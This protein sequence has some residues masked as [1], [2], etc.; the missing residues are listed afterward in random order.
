MILHLEVMQLRVIYIILFLIGNSYALHI[1]SQTIVYHVY[2]EGV[3]VGEMS[4]V[5]EVNDESIKI[6]TNT[7]LRLKADTSY[8]KELFTESIYM[9]NRLLIGESL[10]K[11]NG[12]LESSII[13]VLKGGVYQV[14]ID[15]NK[16]TIKKNDLVAMDFYY[17]ESPVDTQKV[18][19]LTEGK[20]INLLKKEKDNYIS[21]HKNGV[22]HYLY[23]NGIL[24]SF[25]WVIKKT[26]LNFKLVE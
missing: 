26:T 17:F 14:D 19:S 25:K 13:A 3:M 6:Q 22:R 5:R 4:V 23:K 1:H 16:S 15:G 18:Y 11:T 2:S 10:T 21:D 9:N 8:S 20:T 12:A 24:E 7:S